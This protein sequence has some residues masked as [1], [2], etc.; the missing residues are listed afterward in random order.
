MHQISFA[1]FAQRP[2]CPPPPASANGSVLSLPAPAEPGVGVD[3]LPSSGLLPGMPCHIFT[4]AHRNPYARWWQV[5]DRVA[6]SVFSD[7]PIRR[8]ALLSWEYSS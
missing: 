4:N 2:V 8:R 5:C 1:A 7:Q 6:S 3:T